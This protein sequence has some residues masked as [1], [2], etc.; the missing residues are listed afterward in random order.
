[1]KDNRRLRSFFEKDQALRHAKNQDWDT[2]NKIDAKHRALVNTM[3]KNQAVK[4]AIDYYHAAMIFQHGFTV[5]DARQARDLA[6]KAMSMGSEEA[7]WLYAAATDRL[8]MRMDKK[9]KF[10]TQYI[11]TITVTKNGKIKK[12][13]V[14]YPWDKKTTDILRQKYNVPSISF[15]KKRV[16]EIRLTAVSVV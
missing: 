8:L 5:D 11:Q 3:L 6:R 4:T 7:K 15:L 10:G 12:E 16:S 14:V 9:Q 2:I 1:M 13:W